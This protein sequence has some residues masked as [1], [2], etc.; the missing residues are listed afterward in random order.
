[1]TGLLAVFISFTLYVLTH[2]AICRVFEWRPHSKVINLLWFFFLP[3]YGLIFF[4]LRGHFTALAVDLS[5][6]DGLANLAN[7]L[8]LDVVFLIGY[9]DFF[10][11]VERGLS[12]RVMIEISRSPQRKLTQKEI[13]QIYTYDYILDKRLG[14]I[15]KMDCAAKTGNTITLTPKGERIVATTRL[16]RKV[17]NIKEVM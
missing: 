16:I 1:M 6:L 15:L 13:E 10:F 4:G 5:S 11:V 3:V 7:G 2:W 9:T 12:M 17:F 8:L 14:Q